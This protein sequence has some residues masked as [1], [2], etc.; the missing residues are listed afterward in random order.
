MWRGVGICFHRTGAIYG[1]QPA[2]RLPIVISS[3][4]CKGSPA[5]SENRHSDDRW[6]VQHRLLQWR[7]QQGFDKRVRLRSYQLQRNQRQL[8]QPGGE[9]LHQYKASG[10]LVYT[11]GFSLAQPECQGPDDALC[12]RWVARFLG[13]DRRRAPTSLP[14][15]RDPDRLSQVDELSS[16][17]IGW[18]SRLATRL[19][20]R[21]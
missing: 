7:H 9:P 3:T 17:L 18:F 16:T 1:R 5:P 11:V 4:R 8:I 14:R 12:D 10:I 19:P 2:N 20:E 6:R 15:Y 21:Y 13:L